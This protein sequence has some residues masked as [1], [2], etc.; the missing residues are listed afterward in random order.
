MIDMLWMTWN[1][2]AVCADVSA[3][4]GPGVEAKNFGPVPDVD[5]LCRYLIEVGQ[6]LVGVCL[7]YEC[8]KLFFAHRLNHNERS[9][10]DF[11]IY[12]PGE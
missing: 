7:G 2:A 3:F 8:I 6:V 4:F 1:G 9:A 11:S 12:V 5:T 10:F